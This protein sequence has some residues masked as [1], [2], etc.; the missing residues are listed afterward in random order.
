MRNK[1][2]YE[3]K[4]MKRTEGSIQYRQEH[5]EVLKC[6]A[7]L[8][9]A[10]YDYLVA[11]KRIK[12]SKSY[13]SAGYKNFYEYTVDGLGVSKTQAYAYIETI[14]TFS[15]EFIVKHQT[16]GITKILELKN[17]PEAEAEEYIESHDIKKMSVKKLREDLKQIKKTEEFNSSVDTMLEEQ[18]RVDIQDNVVSSFGQMLRKMR[19]DKGYSIFQLANILDISSPYLRNIELGNRLPNNHAFYEKI[20]MIFGLTN[21]QIDLMTDLIDS[22]YSSKSKIASELS[23]YIATDHQLLKF[24]R[25]VKNNSLSSK[26][27]NKI[28][29]VVD[30]L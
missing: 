3:M 13:L 28:M 27:W 9:F 11:V 12:D 14:E 20:V 15:K 22:Y 8:G 2:D 1:G 10:L 7:R 18:E 4:L 21:A 19:L 24:A 25:K 16:I 26:Q 29:K 5:E 17:L 23:G 30:S 6:A